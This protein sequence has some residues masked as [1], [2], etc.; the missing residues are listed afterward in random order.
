MNTEDFRKAIDA[1]E[2]LKSKRRNLFLLSLL[3]LA[4]VVSGAN[5]KE[6]SSLVFKI[7]FTNHENLQWLLIAGIFYSVLRYYAYSEIYRDELFNQ[8][9]KKL[10]NDPTIYHYDQQEEEVKGLLEK[11]VDVWGGDEPGLVEPEYRRIGLLKRVIAYPATQE[12][13]DHGLMYFK[14]YINLNKYDSKWKRKDFLFLLWIELK[15]R[16]NAWVAQR[17]TLDLVAPYLLA[18]AALAAFFYKKFS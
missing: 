13:P 11:A 3:L 16:A 17:E 7:E 10:I 1:D 12:D 15:Y 8:W 6:A 18:V 9:S 2:G 4:I 14:R 5:I